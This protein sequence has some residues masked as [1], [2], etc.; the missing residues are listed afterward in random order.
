MGKIARLGVM[1][2][3]TSGRTS[4]LVEAD[5]YYAIGNN[6]GLKSQQCRGER[7]ASSRPGPAGS[8]DNRNRNRTVPRIFRFSVPTFTISSGVSKARGRQ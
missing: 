4:E 3:P 5:P 2:Y 6:S 8:S 1:L 7:V